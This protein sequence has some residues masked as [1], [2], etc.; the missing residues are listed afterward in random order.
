MNTTTK[1]TTAG[2]TGTRL[3]AVRAAVTRWRARWAAR[4]QYRA[5]DDAIGRLLDHQLPVTADPRQRSA[6]LTRCAGWQEAMANAYA[7]E[8]DPDGRGQPGQPDRLTPAEADMVASLRAGAALF[9]LLAAVERAAA[10]TGRLT[11]HP[12]LLPLLDAEPILAAMAGQ[13]SLAGRAELLRPLYEAVLPVVGDHAAEVIAC[14][15]S[16]G[17]RGWEALPWWQQAPVSPAG[18]WMVARTAF[19]ARW[20]LGGDRRAGLAPVYRWI[21]A[22]GTELLARVRAGAAAAVCEQTGRGLA[23]RL[24]RDTPGPAGVSDTGRRCVMCAGT[25][26]IEPIDTIAGTALPTAL[27]TALQEADQQAEVLTQRHL[28]AWT[29]NTGTPVLAVFVSGWPGEEDDQVLCPPCAL[30][31][32]PPLVRTVLCDQDDQDEGHTGRA[33]TRCRRPFGQPDNRPDTTQP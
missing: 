3:A 19:A 8:C 26:R 12:M 15:P 18:L 33:C 9:G 27:P 10:G 20:R 2:A 13:P 7:T 32:Q 22:A 11:V 24:C 6:L 16:P 5:A 4:A 30:E 14:L 31:V 25:G 29:A 23:C 28:D 1:S 21:N 17:F